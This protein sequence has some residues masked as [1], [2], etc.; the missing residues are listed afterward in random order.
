[1]T[2]GLLRRQVLAAFSLVAPLLAPLPG[3]AAASD[4]PPLRAVLSQTQGPPFVVWS[5]HQATGGIDLDVA[6]AIAA[7]LQVPLETVVLPRPRVEA[8]LSA[9]EAD[10]A[11][12]LGA[13]S[14]PARREALPLSGVL[15]EQTLLLAGHASA[16]PADQP[17]QLPAGA[18]IGTLS[19]ALPARLE[20]Q[21]NEGRLKRDI[22]LS[23]GTLLRKL[24]LDRHP[25]AVTSHP[26]LSW[27]AGQPGAE[28][29]APWRMVLG[30]EA[31]R[32]RVSPRGRF[33]VRQILAA[34]EALQGRGRFGQI[35]AGHVAS[36]LAVV[37]SVKSSLRGIARQQLADLY[38]GRRRLL[39]GG[40]APRPVMSAGTER[41]QFLDTV[42][43]RTPAEFRASWAALQFGGRQRAPAELASPEAVKAHLLQD[44]E[45][46]GFLPLALLDPSLRIVY[47]P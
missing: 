36:P 44:A 30:Q 12:E 35:A 42:V 45:A 15:F 40:Q 39:P 32:C 25:Y 13:A 8:A 6:R 2:Q 43:Q 37:V 29:V 22:A 19:G 16:S 38:L 7:Q 28:A 33:E 23:D 24:A 10:L 27:F 46:I 9:G 17:E 21:F 47:L 3:R 26:S 11:C 1:M 18:T 20:A 4:R 34:L 5:E 14:I 41:E 31:Y